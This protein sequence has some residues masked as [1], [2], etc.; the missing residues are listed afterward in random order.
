[1]EI[2][3]IDQINNNLLEKKVDCSNLNHEKKGQ[4]KPQKE[5]HKIRVK[6]FDQE[7]SESRN[8]ERFA[9]M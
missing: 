4:I 6:I 5:V 9:A 3:N 7:S 2:V 8:Q 1:M